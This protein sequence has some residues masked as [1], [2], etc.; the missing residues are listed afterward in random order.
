MKHSFTVRDLPLEERP[1]E[2]LAKF[3]AETLSAQELL[4]LILGRGIQGESVMMTAQRLLSTFGSLEGVLA[5]SLEDLRGINGIG[6][7]KASQIK[8][9]LELARRSKA[10]QE[11][12]RD[13]ALKESRVT[14]PWTVYELVKAALSSYAKE[15][16]MVLSFDVRNKLLGMDT[17]SV[18]TL[19]ASLVHPRETF[20]AAIRRHADH[21]IIA[22]NHPSGDPEPS[23]EDKEITRRLAESGRILGIALLDHL[24]VGR[25]GYV[26][27][28]EQG[29]L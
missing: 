15:H 8:A 13:A 26:S 22:H 7:A 28:K 14:S 16:F 6:T 10:N 2:R 18:G 11:T 12:M 9:C 3:G 25:A 24:I 20:E 27:F 29:L 17:V 19:N 1:R 5:A 4:A 21:I 23:E